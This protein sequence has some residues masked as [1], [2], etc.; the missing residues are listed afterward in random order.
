MDWSRKLDDVLWTYRTA[1]KTPVG[2]SSYKLVFEK[3]CHLPVELEHKAMWA[4]KKLN[5]E[6][7]DAFQAYESALLKHLHDKK[8]MKREFHPRDLVVL[9]NL[10]FT[11][12]PGKLKSKWSETFKVVHVYHFGVGNL[13]TDDGNVF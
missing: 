1:Y 8:I 13:E 7:A 10:R 4:M 5:L 6:W 2:M 9:Y 12:F 3:A 11:F